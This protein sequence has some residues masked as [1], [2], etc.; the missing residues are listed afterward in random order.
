MIPPRASASSRV[1]AGSS[2]RRWT[3]FARWRRASIRP[4]CATTD[5][6]RRCA[7]RRDARRLRYRSTLHRS[8]GMRRTP[9]PRSISAA[10]RA[11]R[12]PLNTPDRPLPRRFRFWDDD[13]DLWFE[14][15]DSGAGFDP[16]STQSGNGMTNMRDRI[17][18][19]GGKLTITS[20]HGQGTVLRGQVPLDSAALAPSP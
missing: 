16:T 19:V 20:R 9:R 10:L 11:S 2:I 13:E 12:T 15:A 8:A 5:S 3:R 17:E 7:R 4:C 1:S 18:A 14:I 6:S